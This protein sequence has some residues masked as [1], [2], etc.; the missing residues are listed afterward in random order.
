M[1]LANKREFKKS[2]ANRT[3]RYTTRSMTKD[4]NNLL[5]NI[6]KLLQENGHK[7]N[8]CIYYDD[9]SNEAKIK[10]FT[11][12]KQL[13]E[14]IISG[15]GKVFLLNYNNI[16]LAVKIFAY[17][18]NDVITNQATK[19][20]VV[21]KKIQTLI[22]NIFH[23]PFIHIIED[24][25]LTLDENSIM[26]LKTK[27]PY[28]QDVVKY[29]YKLVFTD[30]ADGSLSDFIKHQYKIVSGWNT[31]N[32]IVQIIFSVYFFHK[33]TGYLHNDLH[34]GNM[35]YTKKKIDI[36]Y[37]VNNKKYSYV[38]KTENNYLWTIW[39]FDTCEPITNTSQ[40]KSDYLKILT[41]FSAASM[42]I[43]DE[44]YHNDASKENINVADTYYQNI[45]QLL[46]I[47]NTED[48]FIEKFIEFLL[49]YQILQT[50]TI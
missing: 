23:M 24:C 33:N 32:S 19:E 2:I 45:I 3:S 28:I 31:V 22:D 5:D 34:W 43:R 18:I 50:D 48:E 47:S 27:F 42:H 14:H 35:L 29:H 9:K 39:D 46:S 10:K 8:Y 37:S 25:P 11:L 49:K 6:I 40:Y 41:N 17:E 36:K 15:H 7:H 1:E 13:G 12:M 21:L 20:L 44:L 26:R 38:N 30:V 4:S 16:Q